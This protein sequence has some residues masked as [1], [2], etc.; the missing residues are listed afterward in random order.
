MAQLILHLGSN[1]GERELFLGDALLRITRRVGPI[2]RASDIYET[3][4]WGRTRQP[5]FLN[6]ACRC[7]TA[8]SPTEV[9]QQTQHIEAELGRERSVQWGP[10][11]IDIDIL[12]YDQEV[13]DT[14]SLTIPHPRIGER[15][16]VLVPLAELAPEWVH[17]VTGVSVKSLLACCPDQGQVWKW[18]G[19]W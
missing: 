3:S 19:Q 10:R 18:D 13:I 5:N 6:L 11:T 17:P 4:P 7:D 16:F 9:L 14:P 12:S 8:L 1:E 15:R 2:I